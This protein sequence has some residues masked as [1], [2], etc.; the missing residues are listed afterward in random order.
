MLTLIVGAAIQKEEHVHKISYPCRSSKTLCLNVIDADGKNRS[1]ITSM[2][3]IYLKT[4]AI[5]A[6]AMLNRMCLLDPQINDRPRELRISPVGFDACT[7]CKIEIGSRSAV[8]GR[9]NSRAGSVWETP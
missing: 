4:I 2:N 6:K 1:L 3:I 5:R 8:F 7:K 9:H